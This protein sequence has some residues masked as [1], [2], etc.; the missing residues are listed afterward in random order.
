[1]SFFRNQEIA[2]GVVLLILSSTAGYLAFQISSGPG[3]TTLPPNFFPMLL[4]IAMFVIGILMVIKG[5]KESSAP[6][7]KLMNRTQALIAILVVL[8]FLGFEYVDFRLAGWI[9]VILTML[10]LG[11][12]KPRDLT[13]IPIGIVA[14]IYV[15][16]HYVLGVELPTWI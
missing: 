7:E 9:F 16:F 14:G 8:F 5:V 4:A 15:M 1:M 10:V 11:C 6:L 3:Q 13:L 12:R 2:N